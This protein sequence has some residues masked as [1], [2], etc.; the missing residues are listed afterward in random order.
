MCRRGPA[1]LVPIRA[2]VIRVSIAD[3]HQPVV[4]SLRVM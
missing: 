3:D 2:G 4:Y 1:L